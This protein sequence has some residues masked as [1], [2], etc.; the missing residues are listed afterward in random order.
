MTYISDDVIEEVRQHYDI[1]E[2][3]ASYIDLK[4]TGRNFVGLCPFHPEKTPSFTVSPEKQIFHCFGC[5]TGGNLFSFIMQM[6]GLSFPEAV[7][8]LAEKAGVRVDD[9]PETPEEIKRNK[10]RESLLQMH[11]RALSYY[12]AS[13]WE[14]PQGKKVLDYLRGRGL[15]EKTMQE[16]GLGFAPD[17]WENLLAVFKAEGYSLELAYQ[18]GL[19][20]QKT[21]GRYFDYFRQ[22]LIFPIQDRRGQVIAFGGRSLDENE[23]KYLNSPEST[24]FNKRNVLYGL[25][26]ALPTI[27]RL[28]EALVV[29]GYMDVILLRQHHIEH[30]VAPLGTSLTENQVA[31]LRGRL[32][33]ITLAFDADSGGQQAS[34][35]GLELL[36]NESIDTRVAVLPENMDPAD[37]VQ[38][39]G[40][41][42]FQ[43]N[44]LEKALP[45]LEYRLFMIK[46]NLD[47]Q[48]EEGRV[49][50]WKSA[51]KV[52]ATLSEPVEKETYLKKIAE[53]ISVP[54]EV[55]RGDLE[56][57]I[58]GQ[59]KAESAQKVKRSSSSHSM[60]SPREVA[61]KELLACLMREPTYAATAFE[62]LGP[63]DFSPGPYREIAVAMVKRV[64]EGQAVAP[65]ALLGC[66]S[67][68]GMHK[69]IMQLALP[70][71]QGEHWHTKKTVRDCIRK[72]K[73][74]RWSEE[75]ERLIQ[76][77]K[78]ETSREKTSE[79]LKRIR[80]LRKWDDEL[81]RPG[82]GEDFGG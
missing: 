61:E 39:H 58:E 63:E 59:R 7:K 69:I 82:E 29:E 60:V 40:G 9:R 43:K 20:S 57:I 47:L 62:R 8:F 1:Y 75:R 35:R 32:E 50:Y 67:E 46:N 12:Q 14:S 33:T 28:K 70:E 78:N 72:I 51:R 45:Q 65:A 73:S 4:K 71:L 41:P 79:I 37:Y 66:F 25:N 53:E 76:S 5:Q 3:L 52:L 74:L 13:L 19:L 81:N 21:P 26:L 49:N 54:L 55:L 44:I 48:K 68:P 23:P 34:L 42:A 10:L 22:R 64:R 16:F 56:K 38:K 2:L 77:L 11:R 6:E 31:L 80:D 27:R 30:A 17:G 36:K 18:A 15:Q 24:L